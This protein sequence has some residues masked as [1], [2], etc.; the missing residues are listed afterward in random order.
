MNEFKGAVDKAKKKLIE[1]LANVD[2]PYALAIATYAL[3]LAGSQEKDI[4]FKKLTEKM[5]TKGSPE[6]SSRQK[7]TKS[8]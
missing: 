4:A 1:E 5:K 3:H 8:P 6:N 2:E 7:F